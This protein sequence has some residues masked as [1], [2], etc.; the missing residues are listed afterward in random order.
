MH[1]ILEPS[2][3]PVMGRVYFSMYIPHMVENVLFYIISKTHLFSFW[4][5]RATCGILILLL[6]FEPGFWEVKVQSSSHWITREFPKI[7]LLIMKMLFFLHRDTGWS[8]SVLFFIYWNTLINVYSL[9]DLCDWDIFE[10]L[11]L[12]SDKYWFVWKCCRYLNLS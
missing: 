7:H 8:Y 5:H 4:P 1:L 10:I 11:Y 12:K 9:S 3:L 6:G 2:F